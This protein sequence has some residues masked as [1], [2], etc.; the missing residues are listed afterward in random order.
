MNRC[1]TLLLIVSTIILTLCSHA[2]KRELRAVWVATVANIDWPSTAQLSPAQQRSSFTRLLDSLQ[3]TNFNAVVVQIRPSADAFYP[4]SIEPWSK[5]L[6]GK[7]GQSPSPFYDPLHFMITECHARNMEF[8]AWIN[9]LRAYTGRNPHPANHITYK[10]PEWFYTYGKNT[11]MNAGNPYAV[12]YLLSVI[13]DIITRYDIDALHMDDY[14]YPYTISGQRIPDQREYMLYNPKHRSLE[15]WRRANINNIVFKIQELILA[16]NPEVQF[17]ISPFGV[18]RNSDVDPRGSKTRAGQTNYDN[19]YADVRLWMELGWIDYCAPQLYWERGHR[20]ADYNTLIRWWKQNAYGTYLIS[21]IQIYLMSTSRKSQWQ[22]TDETL[23]Q[24]ALA[25]QTGYDGVC[26]YS[27][28]HFQ[29][30]VKGLKNDL[31]DFVF[32]EKALPP[33]HRH[34][35]IAR[36]HKPRVQAQYSGQYATVR[37][38]DVSPS[39]S[40]VLGYETLENEFV[41]VEQNKSGNFYFQKQN[42]K[43]FFV[44]SLSSNQ[45]TSEKFYL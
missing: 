28:K 26:L 4:S 8:H 25:R 6:T 41:I 38:T 9:P 23:A 19:L 14:F 40:Y 29:N 12:D 43:T 1:K 31:Q 5:Y 13:S 16:K 11:I 35:K 42:Y 39:L 21:G 10:H 34:S 30:N 20:A 44:C 3:A 22:S 24:I 32:S 45:L 36:P 2:Q 17:G 7:S 33:I 18:W 37:V 27:A 15:D